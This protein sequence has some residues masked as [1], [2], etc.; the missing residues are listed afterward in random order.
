MNALPLATRA[1]LGRVRDAPTILDAVDA[2]DEVAVATSRH[3]WR[4]SEKLAHAIDDADPLVAL[5]AVHGAAAD[6][7]VAEALLVPLLSDER[8]H[9]RE[10]AAW[11]LA[12]SEPVRAA[13]APLRRTLEEGGFAG[14][15]A[16]ATLERWFDEPEPPG[17]APLGP[18]WSAGSARGGLTVAQ[19]YLHGEIDGSLSNAGRG[20][21]GGIATLLV[22]LGDALLKTESQEARS[23]EDNG[24]KLARVQLGQAR[25][26]VA[27]QKFNA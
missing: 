1:A 4:A 16:E 22:R 17:P 3:G 26:D 24:I 20:D 6:P 14:T 21:T 5:A 9:L 11:A 8:P 2:F 13:V 18:E 7:Q 23:G 12:A 19:L 25:I 10:H 27:T 15:L